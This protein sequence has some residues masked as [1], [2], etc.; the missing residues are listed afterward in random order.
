M[1]NYLVVHYNT[2]QLTECL[3]KSINKN[4]PQCHIYIFDNSDIYPFMYRQNNI[5]IFDNTNGGYIDFDRFLENYP[6]RSMKQDGKCVS[7][8]HSLS[9]DMCMDLID[10]GFILMD[11]DTILLKDATDMWVEDCIFVG[12]PQKQDYVEIVRLLPYICFINVRMCKDRGIRYF[13]PSFM[14]GLDVN[15]KPGYYYDTGASFYRIA[16]NY[17]HQNI[18][19]SDYII[20]YKGGS[21]DIFHP[22]NVKDHGNV[23]PKEWC[24]LNS[25]YWK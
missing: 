14:H 25:K 6:N 5:T 20:H 13:D 9:V 3:I 17:K 10:D 24:V 4:T 11:S 16:H 1:I 22:S 23:S 8:R 19:V 2:P 12:E 21:W 15:N 7:A 18:L